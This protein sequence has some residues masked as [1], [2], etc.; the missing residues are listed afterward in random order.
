MK[1][2]K[3]SMSREEKLEIAV[4]ALELIRGVDGWSVD[5]SPPGPC[6]NIADEAL[7]RI[8]ENEVYK[9]S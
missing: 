8:R 9:A 4:K 3:Y 5:L 1:R 6:F 7:I 2:G